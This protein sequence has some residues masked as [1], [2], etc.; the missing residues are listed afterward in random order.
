MDDF[1]TASPILFRQRKL[2]NIL[3]S[4]RRLIHREMR[5]KGNIMREFDTG[6][7]VVVRKMV[8]TS[9]NNGVSHKLLFKTKG[10][11]IVLEKATSISYWL[12]SLPFGEVIGRPITKVTESADRMENIPFTMVIHKHV[13]GADTIFSTMVGP[14]ENNPL[15]KWIGVIRRGS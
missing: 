2:F 4:E 6:D 13:Y 11:Y 9:I 14:L 1:E 3:V 10:P 15:D 8:K 7:I 5:N 12:Q